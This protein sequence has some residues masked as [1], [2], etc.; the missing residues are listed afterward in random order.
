MAQWLR[1]CTFRRLASVGESAHGGHG[2]GGRRQLGA[3]P[4]ERM[5]PAR[6]SAVLQKVGKTDEDLREGDIVTYAPMV[7]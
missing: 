3:G 2:D 7:L 6:T 5:L 1:R 4:S